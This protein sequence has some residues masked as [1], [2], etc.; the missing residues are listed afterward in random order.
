MPA[1]NPPRRIT[2]IKPCMVS[3]CNDA[4]TMSVL[5]TRV[6][7]PHW[8]RICQVCAVGMGERIEWRDDGRRYRVS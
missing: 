5:I 1:M 6:A 2:D 7:K 8:L 3:G 4:A